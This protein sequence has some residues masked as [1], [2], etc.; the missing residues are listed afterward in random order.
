MQFMCCA[1]TGCIASG[2]LQVK[3][4]FEEQLIERGLQD[5][6]R[7]ILTGCNGF[8][9]KGPVIVA[10]PDGFFYNEVRPAMLLT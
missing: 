7:I 6:V 9:A 8:C 5:E 3:Q 1:G 10:H 4:A 2:S